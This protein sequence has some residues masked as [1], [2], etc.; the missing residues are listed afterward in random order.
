MTEHAHRLYEDSMNRLRRGLPPP[1]GEPPRP[2]LF[3]P[4]AGGR[5]P[6]RNHIYAWLMRDAVTG[7]E[8]IIMTLTDNG[9]LPLLA[10]NRHTADLLRSFAAAAARRTGQRADLVEYVRGETLDVVD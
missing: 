7:V 10:D 9:P 2:P 3:G 8:N 4:T 1:E 5:R 6:D